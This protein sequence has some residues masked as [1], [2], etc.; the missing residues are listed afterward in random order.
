MATGIPTTAT[1]DNSLVDFSKEALQ[2]VGRYALVIAIGSFL[3]G[4]D[5][6]VVSGALL[7]IKQ[8]FG[9]TAFQ[10]GAVVSVLLLGAIAGALTVGRFMD[11]VG[12]KATLGLVALM[13]GAGIAVAA[14]AN[15]FA[16]LLVGRVIMGLGVGGV[17]VCVP[18]YLSEIAPAQIRG[19]VLTLNQL[20]IVIGLL[21]SYLVDLA[22][23]GS[24]DWRA[25]FAVGLIPTLAL[26]LGSLRLPES[27]AWLM[28]HGRMA[29]ARSEI[30][31]LA[32]SE[33]A[34]KTMARYQREA[35]DRK[36]ASSGQESR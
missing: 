35:E 17:S 32:G 33:A 5:T 3:F 34:D 19:R 28:N 27:P 20:L 13:F 12:R 8:D 7:F 14:L 23:A 9:L 10:Q 6:G 1:T 16:M 4:Y 26:A 21:V 2:K 30:A 29:D 24:H 25:M 11:R 18:T 31:A 15:G 22:F 36:R